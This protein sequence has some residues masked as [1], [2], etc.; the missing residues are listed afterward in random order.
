MQS[1]DE[2]IRVRE[3]ILNTRAVEEDMSQVS[4]GLSNVPREVLACEHINVGGCAR[5]GCVCGK[6]ILNANE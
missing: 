2:I 5:D 6:C 1:L 3:E 4:H